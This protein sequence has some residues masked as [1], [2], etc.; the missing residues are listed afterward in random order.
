MV[1]S[2]ATLG[3]QLRRLQAPL[4]VAS[5]FVLS[6]CGPADVS[7][8]GD[9]AFAALQHRGEAAMGVD[10]FAS[11]HV[12]EP[13]P[14]GGRIV[15]QMKAADRTGESVIRGHMRDIAKAF[16]RGDFAIPGRVHAI[17]QVPGAGA[18]SRLRAEIS[19][20][21]RDIERGGEVRITTRNAAALAAIHEFLA[22]QR[23]DHRAMH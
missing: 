22:F 19:Y 6:A 15:L 16:A 13:L 8:G 17:P 2:F 10:Q 1:S 20:D 5:I 4:L 21:A 9:S 11:A 23:Q 14:D 3:T 18:M 12:F 7:P